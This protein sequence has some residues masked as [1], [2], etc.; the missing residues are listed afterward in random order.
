MKNTMTK[1]F[2]A[3]TLIA[4]LT[5][6]AAA[7]NEFL[8]TKDS[9]GDVKLGMT[10]EEAKQIWKDYKFER[11]ADGEFSAL[12]AVKDGNR[13]LMTMNADE[14]GYLNEKSPIQ[15]EAHIE[16]IEV[17]DKNFQTA[18][19]VHPQMPLEAAEKIYGKVK[20]IARSEIESREYAEFAD[21]P[22]GIDFRLGSRQDFAGVSYQRDDRGVEVTS[23]YVPS[24]FIKNILIVK[25]DKGAETSENKMEDVKFSSSYTDLKAHC[26]E[27]ESQEGSH[28]SYFCKG[29]GNYQIHYFDTATTLEFS[30]ETL[31]REKNT[32]LASQSLTYPNENSKIEWRLANG[33]PFAVI[34]PVFEHKRENGLIKYPAEITSEKIVVKG[35]EGFKRIDYLLEGKGANARA[36]ILADN[37]Y[38]DAIVP[39][40]RIEM[41]AGKNEITLENFLEKGDEDVKY[42]L[43][44][45]K[46]DRMTVTINTVDYAGLEGPIMYG[47]I[48]MPDGE[49]DGAPGGKVFDRVLDETGDYEILVAQN[50]AKSNATNVR[51]KVKITL[52]PAGKK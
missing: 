5:A 28:V 40:K 14:K 35:L 18:E 15:P 31:D 36:R 42:L 24:A 4:A 1:L 8:I 34:M 49:Q 51:F 23:E 16:F 9:V 52:E 46:G 11:T 47:I 43:K 39:A 37:D 32:R 25:R 3:L 26:A 2:L 6:V 29:P 48:I 7:Q 45:E 38:L 33:K 20:N 41:P 19:G 30:A 50:M 22:V 21:Q 27:Q 13:L 17:W 12:I 44:A 10:V